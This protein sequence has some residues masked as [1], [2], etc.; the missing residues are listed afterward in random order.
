MMIDKDKAFQIDIQMKIK[1]E[2]SKRASTAKKSSKVF[3]E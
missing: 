2:N 3:G 1:A